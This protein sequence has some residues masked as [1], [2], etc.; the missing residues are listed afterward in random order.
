MPIVR[1]VAVDSQL[2]HSIAWKRNKKQFD[3][4]SQILVTETYV[5]IFVSSPDAVSTPALSVR[6]LHA[7][8]TNRVIE[9]DGEKA[10]EKDHF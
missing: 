1:Y 3:L 7:K 4:F 10:E 5:D 2:D 9:W 6:L 8:P